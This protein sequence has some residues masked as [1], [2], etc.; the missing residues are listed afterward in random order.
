MIKEALIFRHTK[1]T[2]FGIAEAFTFSVAVANYETNRTAN[3]TFSFARAINAS[4]AVATRD[5]TH[6]R[7]L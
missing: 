1:R 6:T 4:K 2:A 5:P 3:T 7:S